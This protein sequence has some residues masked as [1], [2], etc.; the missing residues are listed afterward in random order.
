MPAVTEK[1]RM[2]KKQFRK[3]L[4]QM[5]EEYAANP[6]KARKKME[7][8]VSTDGDR[9]VLDFETAK[10]KAKELRKKRKKKEKKERWFC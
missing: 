6:K 8:A 2:T 5:Y 7:E 9:V 4:D 1:K 3:A 10:E